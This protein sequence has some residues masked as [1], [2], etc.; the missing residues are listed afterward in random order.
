M[1][2]GLLGRINRIEEFLGPRPF[3]GRLVCIAPSPDPWGEGGEPGSIVHKD[4]GPTGWML[5]DRPCTYLY[6]DFKYGP[7]DHDYA[8]V[9]AL[10]WRQRE[11]L[12]ADD[13]VALH[14]MWDAIGGDGRTELHIFQDA[15]VIP[16]T[17]AEVCEVCEG[18]GEG[19]SPC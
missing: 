7:G 6:V 5:E 2:G 1:S 14:D 12:R 18:R 3:R 8:P 13:R 11:F 16:P 10:N 4:H 9:A 15:A 19:W 17:W